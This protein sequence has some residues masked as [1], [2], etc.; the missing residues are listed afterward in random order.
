VNPAE[1][2]TLLREACDTPALCK[3]NALVHELTGL[4]LLVVW[5]RGGNEYGQ[6]PV[7]HSG[8]DLPQYCRMLHEVP[9]GLQR[10]VTCH[11]LLA[12]AA[13]GSGKITEGRCHGGACVVASPVTG[14]DLPPEAG[15]V[16]ISSCAFT[17]HGRRQGLRIIRKIARD[18]H[19]DSAELRQAY[20]NLPDLPDAK[21][22]I[23]RELVDAA[24]ATLAEALHGRMPIRRADLESGSAQ[25]GVGV[26]LS[27][28]L[29]AAHTPE[30]RLTAG[31]A[32]TTL[33]DVVK[34]VVGANPNLPVTVADI[35]RAAHIT[36]NHFSLVFRRQTGVTF[37]EYLAEKRFERATERLRDLTLSVAEAARQSGYSDPNYF[38]K[39]FHK[40]TGLS[41]REWR[42][43]GGKGGGCGGEASDSHA[44]TRAKTR[45][46]PPVRERKVR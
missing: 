44:T 39:V 29:K 40:R 36:P 2:E 31:S 30:F 26:K 24:A 14:S 42:H 27:S 33:V 4:G 11:S 46:A 35:A 37:S 32:Q 19:L 18:L 8:G 13:S 10:C 28:A 7:C 1:I 6:L 41:P 12:L 17:E 20:D 3:L 25:E 21:R 22:R 5:S 23:V 16:V 34:S 15:L 45:A 38:A 9:Q 43:K